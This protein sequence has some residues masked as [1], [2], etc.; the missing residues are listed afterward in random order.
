MPTSVSVGQDVRV[1]RTF[2]NVNGKFTVIGAV[3]F[4]VFLGARVVILLAIV[5]WHALVAVAEWLERVAST[6]HNI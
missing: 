4:L 3:M 2:G 5:S 6:R 1:T